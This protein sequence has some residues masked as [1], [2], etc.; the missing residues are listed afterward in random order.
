[1][2]DLT[3]R[4]AEPSDLDAIDQM[5]QI[6]FSPAWSRASLAI[7]L[8]PH[9]RRLPLVALRGD[10]PVG[11]ALVWI[12]AD[13]LHIVT[14]GVRPG[15]RRQGI[16]AALLERILA[17]DPAAVSNLI[18][19]EVRENNEAARALYGRFGFLEVA[20]RPGYYPDTHEDAIV[21]VKNLTADRPDDD[22]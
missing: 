1:M 10:L 17:S 8:Q 5:E 15:F 11:Y 7:E 2:A 20:I 22:G 16:A 9:P 19:L 18:T 14:L 12:A 3:I 6:I 21:M 13:E 4:I